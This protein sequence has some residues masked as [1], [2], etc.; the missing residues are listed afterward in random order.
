MAPGGSDD[1]N[2]N[3]NNDNDNNNNNNNNNNMEVSSKLESVLIHLLDGLDCYW[4]APQLFKM[5]LPT[6][7]KKSSAKEASQ[8]TMFPIAAMFTL[9]GAA[10]SGL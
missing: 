10:N 8:S 1:N 4:K 3:N 9:G 5:V 2:N 7:C 6:F